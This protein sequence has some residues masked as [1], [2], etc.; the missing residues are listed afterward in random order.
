MIKLKLREQSMM[1]AKTKKK[2]TCQGWQEELEKTINWLQKKIDCS[3]RD[4]SRQQEMHREL[5]KKQREPEQ[6]IE[7]KT[8]GTILRSK[9]RWYN[10]GKRIR[11][12]FQTL[13][14][15]IVKTA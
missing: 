13:K 3:S 15:G 6:I 12:I 5:E 4:K 8:K 1:Y 11:S 14:K 2:P 10:K 7:H 9:C